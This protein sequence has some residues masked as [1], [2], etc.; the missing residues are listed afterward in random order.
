MKIMFISASYPP[1]YTGIGAYTCNMARALSTIGHQV[2]VATCKV[3][4]CKECEES[5]AGTILRCYSWDELRTEELALRLLELARKYQV[6]LIECPDFLG[7]GGGLLRL[8][9]EVPVCIKAHNSGPVRIGREAENHYFWQRWMQWAAIL[10]NWKQ[11]RDEKYS[12]EHGDVLVTPSGRLMIELEKQGF[13]L[14]DRRFVQPNPICLSKVE[15]ENQETKS[16]TLLFVGRLAIGKGIAFLPALMEKLIPLFP[17]IKLVVAGDDSYARGL[18]SLRKW[19]T[20]RMGPLAAHIEFTG[21]LERE[22]LTCRYDNSW[23]VIVPSLWDTFPTVVLEAMSRAKPVVASPHGGMPEMLE[24]TLCEAVTPGTKQ[25]SEKV[26]MLLGDSELRL[27]AGRSMW[28]K[29]RDCY[30]PE[31]VA[32]QYI[33]QLT[34]QKFKTP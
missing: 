15:P 34:D 2:V 5:D 7:E 21:Q 16:P 19:L 31:I 30:A 9:G 20:K 6:D 28:K 18:G 17:G 27:A 1:C 13:N 25:F 8:K 4:G 23:L 26:S 24:S 32:T 3:E 29:A 14:P 33:K 22:E 11:Y 10:R 12:L